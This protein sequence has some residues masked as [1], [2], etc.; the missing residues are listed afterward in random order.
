MEHEH[1]LKQN[2]PVLTADE[3]RLGQLNRLYH[4]DELAEPQHSLFASYLMVVNMT[5]GDDFYVPTTYIDETR[6]GETA[7]FL[8]LTLDEIEN[9]QLTRTPQFIIDDR[10][11]EEKLPNDGTSAATIPKT[12][13]PLSH[14]MPL[15][16]NLSGEET[17][18]E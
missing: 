1:N 15:P 8:T 18:N 9:K 17:P 12:G 16:P 5:I 13:K 11:M 6:A 4:R 2:L 3:Y 7:V 10:F 14:V